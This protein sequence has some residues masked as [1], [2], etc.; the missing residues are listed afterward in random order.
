M[1][2]YSQQVCTCGCLDKI[3]CVSDEVRK[4]DALSVQESQELSETTK[5]FQ[6]LIFVQYLFVN[7][8]IVNIIAGAVVVCSLSYYYACLHET[9]IYLFHSMGIHLHD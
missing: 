2:T 1:A 4:L 7:N 6:Y 5:Q 3:T 9:Y 8:K